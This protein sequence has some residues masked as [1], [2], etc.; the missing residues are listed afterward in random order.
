MEKLF[1][2]FSGLTVVIPTRN[3]SDI[4]RNAVSSVL[5]SRSNCIRVVVSDNSTNQ[6]QSE[7]LKAFCLACNDS[8][9]AYL[10]PVQPLPMTQHWEWAIHE[11]LRDPA[12]SHFL[13]LTDRMVFTRGSLDELLNLL[14]HY[15]DFLLSYSY[16]RLSDA[17]GTITL[18]RYP[19]THKLIEIPSSWLLH[20]KAQGIEDV[21]R[22]PRYPSTHDAGPT[23]QK[24]ASVSHG[25]VQHSKG[26]TIQHSVE[27][28]TGKSTIL[29]S[30]MSSDHKVFAF[31]DPGGAMN[32]VQRSPLL[33]AEKVEF[34]VGPTQSTL[35]V[36]EFEATLQL[37]LID[38][39]HG[40]P[41]P[42]L[43]YVRIYP[44]LD[45]GALLI[46]DDIHIPTISNFFR[47]LREDDMFRL[48]EVIETTAFFRRT[49]APVFD[50]CGD[51]WFL[52]N[53]N[54]ARFPENPQLSSI[55]RAGMRAWASAPGPVKRGL[56]PWRKT[57][58]RF[59]GID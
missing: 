20:L 12:C 29:L 28:G 34:V 56:R 45:L 10:R 3:R 6:T 7:D 23:I 33:N 8:R 32:N 42:E 14:H 57:I 50:P 52:Q 41:F 16:D 47:F 36:Y 44:H 9:L 53:Y 4:A 17:H 22:V 27:T 26:K 30:H 11:A 58:K 54:I 51:G 43:D 24:V 1:A 31:D 21:L 5:V 15:P 48:E 35:P 49:E 38:G 13:Y 59:T 40:Y 39:A 2:E 37:A 46:V 55:V 25:L 18:D 19:R